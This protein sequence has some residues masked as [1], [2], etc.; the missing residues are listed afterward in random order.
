MDIQGQFPGVHWIWGGCIS[1]V[2]EVHSCIVVKVPKSVGFER[3]H[4]HKEIEIYQ[5]FS[6]NQSCLSIVQCF[7][8]SDNGIFLEY[9]RGKPAISGWQV[10]TRV[11]IGC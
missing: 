5:I 7:H 1:F 2:Y 3:Q 8:I 6:E 10:Q 11:P 9:M 4:F